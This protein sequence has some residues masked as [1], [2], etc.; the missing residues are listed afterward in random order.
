MFSSDYIFANEIDN[1]VFDIRNQSDTKHTPPSSNYFVPNFRDNTDDAVYFTSNYSPP[2][3][4]YNHNMDNAVYYTSN[5]SP[6]SH[7]RPDP[8]NMPNRSKESAVD[9]NRPTPNIGIRYVHFS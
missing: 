1:P 5:Y 2:R 4:N 3:S 7:I 6:T 9:E 8:I